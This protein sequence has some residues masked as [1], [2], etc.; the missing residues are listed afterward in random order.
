MI[1]SKAICSFVVLLLKD[2]MEAA[3]MLLSQTKKE[4]ASPT[5]IMC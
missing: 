1:K 3:Q 4:G 2:D 5:L